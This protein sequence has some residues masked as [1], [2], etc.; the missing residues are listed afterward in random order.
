MNMYYHAMRSTLRKTEHGEGIQDVEGGQQELSWIYSRK[1]HLKEVSVG[2]W[3]S[4]RR[5]GREKQ[6]QSP[7]GGSLPGL[8]DPAGWP[9]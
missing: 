3:T 6:V 1:Y 2:L 7:R 4:G 5:M 8:P 9:Q